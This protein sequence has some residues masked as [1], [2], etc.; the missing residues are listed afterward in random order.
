MGSADL[1]DGLRSRKGRWKQYRGASALERRLDARSDSGRGF[2]LKRG[3]LSF[4]AAARR[5][6]LGPYANESTLDTRMCRPAAHLGGNRNR[7]TGFPCGRAG[8][9]G[10]TRDGARVD[11]RPH[12][13]A[14]VSEGV[15]KARFAA[16][17]KR[18]ARNHECRRA[19]LDRNTGARLGPGRGRAGDSDRAGTGWKSDLRD[20]GDRH[21]RRRYRR[22][23]LPRESACGRVCRRVAGSRRQG[24]W[25]AGN[26]AGQHLSLERAGADAGVW[27][28]AGSRP[29]QRGDIAGAQRDGAGRQ[30]MGA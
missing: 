17:R 3:G 5:S 15:V 30:E 19:R 6:W 21:A 14:G 9:T 10:S 11:T 4:Q 2:Q 8:P 26:T 7:W 22:G 18:Y 13:C 1:A 20:Q 25:L 23:D 24:Y 29:G 28:G 16:F 27:S 12:G